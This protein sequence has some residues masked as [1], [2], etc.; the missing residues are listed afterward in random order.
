MAGGDGSDPASRICS[1]IQG[2]FWSVLNADSLGEDF[3]LI[4]NCGKWLWK[5]NLTVLK[6]NRIFQDSLLAVSVGF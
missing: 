6:T 4:E 3:F 5:D 2:D 1:S